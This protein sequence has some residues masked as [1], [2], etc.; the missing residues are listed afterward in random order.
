MNERHIQKS[1]SCWLQA[2]LIKMSPDK[3]V[4][5]FTILNNFPKMQFNNTC[6]N[7]QEYISKIV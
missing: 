4:V 6:F 2:P 3:T 5:I 1:H 7:N